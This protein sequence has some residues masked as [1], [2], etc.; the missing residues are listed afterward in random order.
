MTIDGDRA[1]PSQPIRRT[2]GQEFERPRGLPWSDDDQ[3]HPDVNAR[4][5]VT[6]LPIL[7]RAWRWLP[8]PFRIPLLVIG[9]VIY[10]W[11][12]VSDRG[13][14]DAPATAAA[15]PD[16]APGGQREAS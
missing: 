3:E 9:A 13:E 5:I 16:T 14:S 1:A 7:R 10:L 12:R 8:G 2:I 6:S 11:R 4:K 15:D